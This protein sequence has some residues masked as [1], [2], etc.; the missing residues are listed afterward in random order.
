M[1]LIGPLHPLVHLHGID[2]AVHAAA[3]RFREHAPRLHGG[4][5]PDPMRVPHGAVRG[6]GMPP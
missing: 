6:L 3:L 1:R 5:Q 4:A 2:P